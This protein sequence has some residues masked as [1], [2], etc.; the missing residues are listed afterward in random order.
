[1]KALLRWIR[2]G[3][4]VGDSVTVLSGLNAEDR[5][6]ISA[7]GKLYNGAKIQVQ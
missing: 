6:I 7:E 4:A 1:D 5:V 2:L 3:R